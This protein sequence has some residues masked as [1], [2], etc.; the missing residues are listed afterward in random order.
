MAAKSQSERLDRLEQVIQI[1]AEDHVDMRE[2]TQEVQK[3]I[4]DLATQTARGF[5][6]LVAQTA[7]TDRR[8]LEN[9]KRTRKMD[10]SM[11]QT[12]ERMKQTDERM[13]QTDERIDKL[14]SA[15]GHFISRS[16]VRA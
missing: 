15:I 12:D 8:I 16:E 7:E 14:V 6:L 13:K 9:E 11:K 5:E 4:A 3:L 10:E 1:I 2:Q